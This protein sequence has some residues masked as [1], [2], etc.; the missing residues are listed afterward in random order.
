MLQRPV[1]AELAGLPPPQQTEGT[2]LVPVLK[3]PTANINDAASSQFAHCCEKG[4]E[5]N[6]SS[7]CGMCGSAPSASISYMGY[8]VRSATWRWVEWHKWNGTALRPVCA[9]MATELYP[10]SGDSGLDFDSPFEAANIAAD[11]ATQGTAMHRILRTKFRKA[12]A[13]CPAP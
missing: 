9:I 4:V 5:V 1:V 6:A 2:S 11:H 12:F 13:H 10:H 8:T 3:D 7:L